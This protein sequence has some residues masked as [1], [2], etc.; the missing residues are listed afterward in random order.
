MWV[1]RRGEGTSGSNL[2]TGAVSISG[3]DD[4]FTDSFS[5]PEGVKVVEDK[6]LRAVGE[7]LN[8]EEVLHG[9]PDESV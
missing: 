2:G 7:V 8:V 9:M 4:N 3:G 1:F 6:V 5:E